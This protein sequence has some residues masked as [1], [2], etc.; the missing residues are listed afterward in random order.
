MNNELNYIERGL[1]YTPRIWSEPF[2]VA[3]GTGIFENDFS[4]D[5]PTGIGDFENEISYD[6]P[7]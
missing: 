1:G 6:T 3:G 7:K 5:T 2:L 4:H